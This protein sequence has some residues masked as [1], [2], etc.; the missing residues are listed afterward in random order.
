ML[1]YYK[2]SNEYLAKALEIDESGQGWMKVWNWHCDLDST[3]FE[4]WFVRAGNKATTIALYSKAVVELKNGIAYSLNI[5]GKHDYFVTR[6]YRLA[7]STGSVE[8]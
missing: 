2:K 7:Y 4:S 8:A 5:E 6:L 3:V 1:Q